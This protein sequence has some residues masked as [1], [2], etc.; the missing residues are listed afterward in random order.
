MFSFMFGVLGSVF[1]WV[2]FGVVGFIVGACIFKHICP[3]HYSL[4]CKMANGEEREIGVDPFYGE[5]FWT[6]ISCILFWPL[7]LLALIFSTITK[8]LWK[9][10]LP[11]FYRLFKA[12]ANM[13]PKIKIEKD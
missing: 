13:I 9:M 1:F 7:L 10:F 3:K 4:M 8:V 2:G 6:I 11:L 5:V 12:S